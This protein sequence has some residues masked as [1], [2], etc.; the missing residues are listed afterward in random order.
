M[1]MRL[2]TW[3]VNSLKARLPFVLHWLAARR[4]DVVGIQELKLTDEQ[5]PHEELGKAGYRAV[6]HGQKAWNGVAILSREEATLVGR[7]LPGGEG[8]GA[9]LLTAEVCGLT[10]TTIYCPNGKRIGHE[11]FPRKLA[12]LDALA[13]YVGG[14]DPSRPAILCGDFNIC[15]TPLDTWDEQRHRGSIHH[16]DEERSR[17][18]RLL[19]LGLHDLFRELHPDLRA[20]SWWDYRGG[21][22]HRNLGLRIDF[23][24][25]TG[26]VRTRVRSVEIDRDYRKKKEGLVASDHAPVIAD[27]E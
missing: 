11:D 18:R 24:L 9:R 20:F 6:V 14:F 21:A 22:F 10:F 8:L 13:G 17:F 15:P 1:P 4:P 25:G 23:L 27:L 3:N 19:D 12:W 7:G 2:A 16:T 26:T 5:F